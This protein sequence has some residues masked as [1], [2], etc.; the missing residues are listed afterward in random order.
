LELS[1][2]SFIDFNLSLADCCL[3]L[4]AEER[5]RADRFVRDQDRRAYIISHFELRRL[6]GE[7]LNVAPQDLKFS[8]DEH[9]KP[10][11][12]D[13]CENVHFNISHSGD[14]C[15][16]G[17]SGEKIGVDIEKM[18][19]KSDFM[20]ISER[21]FARNECL[22]IKCRALAERQLAF[23]QIWTLKEAYVKAIGKG[24]VYGFEKF[25]VVSQ[26]AE[27]VSGIDGFSLGLMELPPDGYIAAVCQLA[28]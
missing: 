14:Y 18:S 26:G 27:L 17:I 23:Y 21:F 19:D 5:G 16:I 10:Y 12:P 4:S 13:Y 28:L 9:G 22:Y 1:L 11:L 15:L 24:I 8:A 2:V 25:S 20:G 7:K 3:A 6:L